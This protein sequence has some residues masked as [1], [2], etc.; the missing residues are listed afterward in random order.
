[1]CDGKH[2]CRIYI[3]ME[4]LIFW[5]PLRHEWKNIWNRL[6]KYW[7]PNGLGNSKHALF[8]QL[9]MLFCKDRVFEF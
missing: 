5:R 8:S 9:L 2:S 7:L 1:M 6:P 3:F 4:Y